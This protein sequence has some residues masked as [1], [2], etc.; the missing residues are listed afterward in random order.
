M[1]RAHEPQARPTA[2]RRPPKILYLGEDDWSF[3]V[4]LLP[5]SLL[6][7]VSSAFLLVSV[8][9]RVTPV[10]WKLSARMLGRT[11]APIPNDEART[12][13]SLLISTV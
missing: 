7:Y 1:G 13:L 6:R 3:L 11:M 5:P 2:A 12:A 8:F 4:H 10:N 9:Y